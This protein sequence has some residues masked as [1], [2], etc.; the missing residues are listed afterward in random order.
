MVE[1]GGMYSE[2]LGKNKPFR[3]YATSLFAFSALRNNC[4]L[5]PLMPSPAAKCARP[6]RWKLLTISAARAGQLL[7]NAHLT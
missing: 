3:K 1:G 2:T 4:D 7:F 5:I 6:T